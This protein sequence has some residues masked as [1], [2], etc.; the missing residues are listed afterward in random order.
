MSSRVDGLRR[1]RTVG[2]GVATVTAT[3]SYAGVTKSTR[4]AIQVRP[5]LEGITVGRRRLS[6]VSPSATATT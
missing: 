5:E 6:S 4:F 2:P 1:I 3:V